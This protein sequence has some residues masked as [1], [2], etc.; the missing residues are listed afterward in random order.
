MRDP[1]KQMFI[2]TG[3]LNTSIKPFYVATPMFTF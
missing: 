2:W 1:Q 3:H